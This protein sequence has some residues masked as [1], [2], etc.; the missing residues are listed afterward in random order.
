MTSWVR[1]SRS[2]HC[3]FFRFKISFVT[4]HKSLKR[5]YATREQEGIRCARILKCTAVFTRSLGYQKNI[6][7]IFCN[8]IETFTSERVVEWFLWDQWR[9]WMFRTLC[10]ICHF[11]P[12]HW[13][14]IKSRAIF[15]LF[16]KTFRRNRDGKWIMLTTLLRYILVGRFIFQIVSIG[17]LAEK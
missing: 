3:D 8:F 15:F 13:G 17:V 9:V 5:V 14:S 6:F 12:L 10:F 1:E 16:L 7:T 4:E 2:A 11:V